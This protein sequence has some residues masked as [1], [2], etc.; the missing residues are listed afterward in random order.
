M[1]AENPHLIHGNLG[2]AA[3]ISRGSP[4]PISIRK[5]SLRG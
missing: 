2:S 1:N 5:V 3:P 4:S